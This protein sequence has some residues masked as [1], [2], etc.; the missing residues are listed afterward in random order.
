MRVA[1][2]RLS[3]GVICI[4][5]LAALSTLAVA[6]LAPAPALA[7]HGETR[8][9][10]H[11]PDVL[12]LSYLTEVQLQISGSGQ[13]AGVGNGAVASSDGQGTVGLALHV[14][15]DLAAAVLSGTVD[16]TLTGQLG[17]V[18]SVIGTSAS[19]QLRVSATVERSTATH[20]GGA[21]LQVTQATARIGGRQAPSVAFEAPGLAAAVSGGLGIAVDVT[22]AHLAGWYQ[23]VTLRLLVEQI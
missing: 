3:T 11:L 18:F 22:E 19:G 4:R 8:V 23:G 5:I 13:L 6:L 7:Q 14:D 16:A 9:S 2:P 10:V 21:I 20:P 15:A 12:V 1:A 17:G